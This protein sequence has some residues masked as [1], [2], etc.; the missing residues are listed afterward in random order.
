MFCL[1]GVFAGVVALAVSFF[2][3]FVGVG[4]YLW[5]TAC[6]LNPQGAGAIAWDPI[7]ITSPGFL[8]GILAIF[9]AG[10]LWEFRR[11]SR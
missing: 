4:I 5:I 9:V 6:K 2:V 11:A 10:F 3:L 1:T 8:L 7:S